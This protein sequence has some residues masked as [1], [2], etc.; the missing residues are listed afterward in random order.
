M[1]WDCDAVLFGL[2][3]VLVDSAMCVERHWWR[4]ATEHGLA[5]APAVQACARVIEARFLLP[6]PPPARSTRGSAAPSP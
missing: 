5:G 1:E 3:G 6:R 4:W 2:D